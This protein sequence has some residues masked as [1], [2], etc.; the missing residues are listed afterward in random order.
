MYL[1]AVGQKLYFVYVTDSTGDHSSTSDSSSVYISNNYTIFG[2]SRIDLKE[3]SLKGFL[4]F[5]TSP[6]HFD[7]CQ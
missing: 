6:G 1:N 5:R 2:C 4:I 3:T 7:N